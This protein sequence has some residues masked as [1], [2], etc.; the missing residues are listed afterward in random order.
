MNERLKMFVNYLILNLKIKSNAELASKLGISKS[1]LSEILNGKRK[2]SSG[3]V[4]EIHN[5]FPDLNRSWLVNGEG[6][7]IDGVNSIIKPT[8]KEDK[9]AA[10]MAKTVNALQD[11]IVAQKAL[12]E[13]YKNEIKRLQRALSL[14]GEE[15]K[16][17]SAILGDED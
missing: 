12:I 8:A 17:A 3:I 11:T 10:I 1:Q 16:A 15:R 6:E 5:L 7:M 4:N 9:D 2:V 14:K 13:L